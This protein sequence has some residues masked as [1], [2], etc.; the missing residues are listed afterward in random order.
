MIVGRR[1][2][3]CDLVALRFRKKL[4]SE[5]NAQV[6]DGA[7]DATGSN[8]SQIETRKLATKVFSP[9]NFQ[10]L[11]VNFFSLHLPR[12]RFPK[13]LSAGGIKREVRCNTGAIPVAVSCSARHKSEALLNLQTTAVQNL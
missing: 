11:S 6:C 12:K 2:G 7:E 8:L 4:H 3:F 1:Y 10:L 9:V 5:Q 13:A